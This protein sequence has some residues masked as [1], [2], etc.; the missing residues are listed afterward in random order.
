M[1]ELR[2]LC[3]AERRLDWRRWQR[4]IDAAGFDLVLHGELADA[5]TFVRCTFEGHESGF[6]LAIERFDA[7]DWSLAPGDAAR[8]AAFDTVVTLTAYANAQEIAGA[9]TAAAAYAAAVEGAI[10]DAYFEERV[11]PGEEALEWA[12]GK[13]PDARRQFDGPSRVRASLRTSGGT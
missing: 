6:D 4:E 5:P 7:A 3:H 10:L 12:R 1:I 2:V 8:V 11:V 9:L 13:L